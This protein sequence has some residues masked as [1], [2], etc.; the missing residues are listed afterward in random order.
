MDETPKK[1]SLSEISHLFLS[2][3][4]DNATGGA[5]PSDFL[6]AL[7]EKRPALRSIVHGPMSASILLPKNSRRFMA[8]PESECTSEQ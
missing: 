8:P 1:K 3:V 2:S 5:V 6:P 7:R 4:R